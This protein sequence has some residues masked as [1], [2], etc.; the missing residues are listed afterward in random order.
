MY[1]REEIQNYRCPRWNEWPNLDLYMDQ[2]INLLE[3][4]VSIFYD[5]DQAKPVTSTMINNYVK[6][7]IVMPSKKKKYQRDHLAYLYVVFLLKSVLNLTDICDGIAF[8]GKLHSTEEAYN[9]FCDEIES[10]L[11]IAFGGTAK[12]NRNDIQGIEIIRTIALAFSY[13]LLA[14]FYISADKL[15]LEEGN[16]E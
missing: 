13:T 4:N 10:A 1:T 14:R 11:A 3:E 8:L 12:K 2:V 9:I 6:Q 5:D 16:K 15:V 7:K